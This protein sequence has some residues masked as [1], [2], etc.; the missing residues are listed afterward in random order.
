MEL[1]NSLLLN[2]YLIGIKMVMDLYQI[3][4]VMHLLQ[5]IYP[6]GDGEPI[7]N[8][9]ISLSQKEIIRKERQRRA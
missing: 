2:F 9:Q 6:W 8:K 3:G 4:Y 5:L 7:K 1:Y